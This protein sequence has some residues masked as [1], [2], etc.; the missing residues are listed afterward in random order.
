MSC[1]TSNFVARVKRSGM[2]FGTSKDSKVCKWLYFVVTKKDPGLLFHF[3][4]LIS[5]NVGQS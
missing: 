3:H 2:N 4:V 1:N 5:V